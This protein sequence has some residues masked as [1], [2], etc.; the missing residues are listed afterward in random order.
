MERER[1]ARVFVLLRK[2]NEWFFTS[3]CLHAAA[4]ALAYILWQPMAP[5]PGAPHRYV[6]PPSKEQHSWPAGVG[7]TQA[8]A[9]A[10]VMGVVRVARMVAWKWLVVEGGREGQG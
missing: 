9:D 7:G 5:G 1:Q 4:L 3:S 2:K 6:S 10:A 8:W